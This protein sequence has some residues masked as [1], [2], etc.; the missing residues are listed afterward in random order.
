MGGLNQNY[1]IESAVEV[2]DPATDTWQSR[3]TMINARWQ[4]RAAMLDG[5]IYVPGGVGNN[6]TFI[7]K[8]ESFLP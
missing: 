3:G 5:Y 2:Y 8:M 6:Y 7:S 4:F 1:A